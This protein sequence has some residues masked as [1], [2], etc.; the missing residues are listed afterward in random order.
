MGWEYGGYIPDATVPLHGPSPAW[1]LPLSLPL[2][3]C[4]TLQ[5]CPTLSGL[6]QPHLWP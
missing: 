2:P 4:V 6:Q 1:P 3:C 5:L